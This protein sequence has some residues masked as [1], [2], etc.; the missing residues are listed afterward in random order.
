VGRLKGRLHEIQLHLG[1]RE[2]RIAIIVIGALAS[3]GLA[4]TLTTG[5]GTPAGAALAYMSAVDRGDAAYVWAH[6]I[7]ESA[8][9]PA[10][11]KALFDRKALVAQLTATAHTRSGF[12]VQSVSMESGGTKV[13]I[14]FNTPA[15]PRTASL[16]LP[17]GAPHSWSVVVE[18]SRLD[19]NIPGG[20][21]ALGVD[22]TVVPAQAGRELKLAVFPGSHKITLGAS[23]I[24]QSYSAAIDVEAPSPALTAVSFANVP[25]TEAGGTQAEQTVTK[26]FQTCVKG[27]SLA[28][29]GCPQ[30]LPEGDA[31]TGGLHWALLNDPT[32]GAA[33]GLDD[34]SVLEVS[35][36]FVMQLRYGSLR[37]RR[38]RLLGV[39]SS[40]V[41]GLLWDGQAFKLSSF[42]DASA[43]ADLGRPSATDSQVLSALK[44]KFSSCQ[45]I[46]L[47]EQP[48]CP[49]SV[50]AFF[51]S[52]FVWHENSDPAQGASL[53]W[54][55]TR[56][57][58][59][60]A[61]TYE[62]TVDYDS[63]PTYS[64]TRRMH[65]SSSGQYTADLYWDGS[66][67][68]YIGLEK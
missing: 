14:N 46:Q 37:L 19:L 27:T 11:D 35:G 48:G 13:S 67:V 68:V 22:G 25:V 10:G 26:A 17:G 15:G 42:Q 51:A 38:D 34:K 53:A 1:A 18:P 57:L 59:T 29:S 32:S 4:F 54:D 60:V 44:A 55:G 66:R 50:F 36:H 62:F 5:V 64:P 61:G 21:G 30:S 33:I 16:F 47:A 31:S 63:T 6:S 24:Y 39:G 2:E 9:V 52:K 12:R 65:D 56:S 20:A 58:F 28:P 8:K 41:A 49:Q 23:S 3:A 40:Y 7:I 43:V 45:A